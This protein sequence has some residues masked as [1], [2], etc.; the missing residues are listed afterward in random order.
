M[1]PS[2]VIES[3]S[4]ATRHE[5][6]RLSLQLRASTLAW[7]A[8][9][10]LMAA[11]Y[12][13]YPGQL[14]QAAL[15]LTLV[16]IGMGLRFFAPLQPPPMRADAVRRVLRLHMLR[17][18]Y[19]AAAQGSAG[20]LLFDPANP[21]AQMALTIVLVSSC[22]GFSFSVSYHGP[23]LSVAVFLLLGPVIVHLLMGAEPYSWALGSIGLAFCFLMLKL[24]RERTANLEE[25]IQLR[26][27]AQMLREE[28]QRFFAAANHDLHQPVM[29][30]ALWA[31]VLTQQLDAQALAED[32][33]LRATAG[34][35]GTCTT[36]LQQL[37]DQLL[38]IHRLESGA[39]EEPRQLV[40]LA[41]VCDGLRRQWLAQAMQKQIQLVVRV[42]ANACV[43]ANMPSLHRL[44]GN[45][46]DNAV[47]FTPPCG[48]IAVVVRSRGHA[49]KVE[50]RDNGIGIALQDQERIFE[51]FAQTQVD[52]SGAGHGLGL[53][54][55]QRLAR[56]LAGRIE[57]RS[58][59]GHG[60]TFSLWL[61]KAPVN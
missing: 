27:E 61:P 14:K 21:V 56:R 16:Y 12:F 19:S 6:L 50:V 55:A 2:S 35:I 46:L 8:L 60:S 13:G 59:P 44:I 26:Y 48:R 33:P 40:A 5:V 25:N 54:I 42:P 45:L 31:D 51:D 7:Q 3:A 22:I 47:K 57:V 41:T 53:G 43:Q 20:W 17:V 23:T 39:V 32:D 15:W 18:C 11:A 58:C 30:I 9:L 4:L 24:I 36:T 28:R 49:W 52:R 10:C 1:A 37:L 34:R 38:T 29:A